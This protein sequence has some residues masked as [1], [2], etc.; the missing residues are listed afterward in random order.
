[1]LKIS[2]V[3][4]FYNREFCVEK[5][6][7]SVV[8]QLDESM[9]LYLVDDGSKDNTF[10][11]LKAYES[12]SVT[13]LRKPN[14]G[15]VDSVKYAI[16]FVDSEFIAI[17]GSGDISLPRR[18]INQSKF[19]DENSDYGVVGCFCNFVD[20]TNNSV[21]SKFGHRV[22]GS[23]EK[24][25]TEINYFTHGEVMFR[26]SIYD[27]VGGYR[28]EFQFSQDYDL[29]CRMS[30][31]CKFYTIP[32]VFYNRMINVA[33]SVNSSTSKIY[34]QSLYADL[35][36]YCH[37]CRMTGSQDP[38][39]KYGNN[40]LLSF[41]PSNRVL[42]NLWKKSILE[43]SSNKK[44]FL[45]LAPKSFFSRILMFSIPFLSNFSKVISYLFGKNRI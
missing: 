19:L 34:F 31:H 17:H 6:V 26:R 4:V 3:S 13:V 10:L 18:F 37:I 44:N 30:S 7:E 28:A 24:E 29:W 23:V 1:M 2:I 42:I 43:Y 33:G 32:E 27:M 41:T 5:S 9:H 16:D 39:D 11:K 35:A 20:I 8:E 40:A 12:E 45:E 15:F 36:R 21:I 22:R 38:V 14:T 25:I